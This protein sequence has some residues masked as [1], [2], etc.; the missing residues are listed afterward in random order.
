MTDM[1]PNQASQENADILHESSTTD[2]NAGVLSTDT[3]EI[4][5]SPFYPTQSFTRLRRLGHEWNYPS[6][7]LPVA[8]EIRDLKIC[9][10]N[11]LNAKWVSFFEGD[12]EGLATS[13]IVTD[14]V[15][16]EGCSW[17]RREA[18]VLEIARAL[19][20]EMG[21]L[22]LQECSREFLARLA[23]AIPG[24]VRLYPG[25]L[26]NPENQIACLVNT[27]SAVLHVEESSFSVPAFPCRKE[28]SAM[29][30][31][32][33]TQGGTRYQ[34]FHAHVPGSPDLPGLTEFAQFISANQDP[35]VV[36]IAAGD[37][38]FSLRAVEAVFREAGLPS[39][40]RLVL[41]NTSIGASGEVPV[42]KDIDHILLIDDTH[43]GFPIDLGAW[44]E[45]TASAVMLVNSRLQSLTEASFGP[46]MK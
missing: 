38:N 32:L 35:S 6:D 43:T 10:F 37:M 42:A 17:T 24:T 25:R 18:D 22:L 36:R 8:A 29:N 12:K 15:T 26:D 41:G 16:L 44:S 1:Q 20:V 33:S 45:E 30:L 39:F 2:E 11:V 7:H 31:R 23:A 5:A 27:Q 13:R 21:L 4:P 14:H 19:S 28:Y 3:V 9:S 34:V 46:S 40:E